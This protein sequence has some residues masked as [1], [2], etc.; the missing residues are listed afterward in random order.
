M[1]DSIRNETEMFLCSQYGS[2]FIAICVPLP[3]S[4]QVFPKQHELSYSC[5]S[6]FKSL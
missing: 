1:L 6:Q 5:L 2:E 4:R 3:P